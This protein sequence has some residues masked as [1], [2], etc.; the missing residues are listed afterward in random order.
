MDYSNKEIITPED[1]ISTTTK[2]ILNP[3]KIQPV[4]TLDSNIDMKV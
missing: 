3:S 4:P 2:N 1:K